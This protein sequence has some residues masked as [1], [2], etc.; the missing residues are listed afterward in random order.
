MV[1]ID[2]RMIYTA[3]EIRAT[4]V[5]LLKSIE[6]LQE[7]LAGAKKS[8][9]AV[10]DDPLE[11]GVPWHGIVRGQ[12]SDIDRRCASLY[13]AKALYK[14]IQNMMKDKVRQEGCK[15]ENK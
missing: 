13:T 11:S 1:D 6:K 15:D 4:K 2:A 3:E 7:Q 9:E 8:L 5:N 12:G 10:M 14:R